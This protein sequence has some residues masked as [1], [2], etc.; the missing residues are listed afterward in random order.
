VKSTGL[1]L[2]CH[3]HDSN[4]H[5]P[6]LDLSASRE[7]PLDKRRDGATQAKSLLSGNAGRAPQGKKMD[8]ATILCSY[9]DG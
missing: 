6:A 9:R 1:G 7:G 2:F 8:K 4:M 5:F 3:V